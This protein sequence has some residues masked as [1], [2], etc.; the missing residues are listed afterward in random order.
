MIQDVATSND[1]TGLVTIVNNALLPGDYSFT[2]KSGL[3]DLRSGDK[4]R[5]GT[6]YAGSCTSRPTR[7]DG[8]GVGGAVYRYLGVGLATYGLLIDPGSGDVIVVD[9]FTLA[10]LPTRTTWRMATPSSCRSNWTGVGLPGAQYRFLGTADEGLALDLTAVDYF[11]AAHW[12]L[13]T[14]VHR[15]RST[16]TTQRRGALGRS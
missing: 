15:P 3:A 8:C 4:V 1:L 7:E 6:S 10:V 5:L 13:M 2:T 16:R 9:P 12:E 14:D 11:D